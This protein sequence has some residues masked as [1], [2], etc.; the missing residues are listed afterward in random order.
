MVFLPGDHVLNK[1]ITVANKARLTMRGESSSGNVATVV[2]NGPVGLNF[3]NM[4]KLKMHSL[5]FTS[6]SRVHTFSKTEINLINLFLGLNYTLQNIPPDVK[7]RY[8]LLLQ[9]TI[10][11]ELANCSFHDTTG[12]ALFVISSNITLAGN[13]DFTHNHCEPNTCLL[14]GGITAVLSSLTFIGNTTF[15]ENNA[16]YAGAG[17]FMLFCI[18]SSTGNINFI[19]NYNSD[20]ITIPGLTIPGLKVKYNSFLASGTIWTY[21][22]SLYTL[23]ESTTLSTTQYSL[24]QVVYTLLEVVVVVQSMH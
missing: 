23:M 14:G 22:S 8:A 5:A 13:T 17:I 18:L 15:L 24:I 21:R 19:N 12:T 7:L 2:C 4:V 3:T 11:T 1:S 16:N 9:S 10:S 6:C 20:Q